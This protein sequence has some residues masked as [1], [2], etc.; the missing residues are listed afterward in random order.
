MHLSY[1]TYYTT[2]QEC[3][4]TNVINIYQ[5]SLLKKYLIYI[6]TNTR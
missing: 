2:M 3:E 1:N 5:I 4:V 6:Q